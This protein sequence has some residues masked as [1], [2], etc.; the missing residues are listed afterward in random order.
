MSMYQDLPKYDEVFIW[1][2][3]AR[4]RRRR[5]VAA[6]NLSLLFC[7]L[8]ILSVFHNANLFAKPVG[9]WHN[10][11]CKQEGNET[12]RFVVQ[13]CLR[14]RGV[15]FAM[16]CKYLFYIFR[17]GSTKYGNVTFERRFEFFLKVTP[18]TKLRHIFMLC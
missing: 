1:K 10:F 2:R 11:L 13:I 16:L 3:A 8:S 15:R 4:R 9:F 14:A 18:C 6:K 7:S 17:P 12:S 5:R